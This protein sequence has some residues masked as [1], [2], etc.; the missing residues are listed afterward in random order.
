[1]IGAGAAV[2]VIKFLEPGAAI[3][4][5]VNTIAVGLGAGDLPQEAGGLDEVRESVSPLFGGGVGDN[6]FARESNAA[7]ESKEIFEWI[8]WVF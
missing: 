7:F 1:M 3:E 4:R 8:F 2:F 6:I 5:S